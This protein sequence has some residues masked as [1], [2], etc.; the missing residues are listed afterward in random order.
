VAAGDR[1]GKAVRKGRGS[2]VALALQRAIYDGQWTVGQR[3]PNERELGRTFGVSRSTVRE[4]IRLL[5]AQGVIQVRRGVTG[6]SFIV[7]PTAEQVG[8]GLA[9]LIRFGQAKPQDFAEFR[10]SFEPETARLAAT[11]ARPEHVEQL[12]AIVSRLEAA[13]DPTV[14]WEH[15]LELDIAFHEAVATASQNVIR[16]AVMLA[17]HGAFRQSSLVISRYDSRDWRQE[18]VG[19]LQAIAEAIAEHRATDAEQAMV[20]HLS[21]N[22]GVAEE[23]LTA[24][25]PPGTEA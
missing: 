23:L 4:A 5:E 1:V 25:A 22:V 18:Q 8:F 14:S 21:R 2:E 11:R 12:R 24:S 19:Q 10:R 20:L 9:A 17:V 3:L 15:F 13:V 16:V 7:E 6:G